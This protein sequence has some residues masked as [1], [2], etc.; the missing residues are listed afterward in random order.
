MQLL[1]VRTIS[2]LFFFFQIHEFLFAYLTECFPYFFFFFPLN[3]KIELNA[4]KVKDDN[5]ILVIG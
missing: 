3:N 2:H 4:Q 5:K 1:N